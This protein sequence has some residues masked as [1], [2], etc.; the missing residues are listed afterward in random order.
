MAG[1][2]WRLLRTWD[3]PPGFNMAF[4]EA[5]LVSSNATPVLRLYTWSPGALSLGYFQ[6][7]DEVR[8]KLRAR[9]GERELPPMVRRLT[10]GGAIDVR[11]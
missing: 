4:D 3:A 11:S 10:G 5:L 7:Y 9:M 6:R 8:A 1:E 2:R